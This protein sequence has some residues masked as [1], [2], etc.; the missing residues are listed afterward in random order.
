MNYSPYVSM[1]ESHTEYLVKKKQ[2]TKE[3]IKCNFNC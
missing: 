3:F 2:V 1:D